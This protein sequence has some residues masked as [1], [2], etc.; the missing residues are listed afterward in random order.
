M[1][2]L[3][4]SHIVLWAFTDSPRL[5]PLRDT[6]LSRNTEVFVSVACW[7]ELAIKIGLGKL[8]A[9]IKELRWAARESGF[10]ELPVLGEHAEQLIQLP[11]IHKD[12]FDRLLVAQAMTEPMRLVTADDKLA[13]YSELVW[14]LP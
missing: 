10:I 8:D 12:P 1:R 13:G 14:T 9:D 6:L 3:L 11:P 7:W 2:L 5:E 4:D